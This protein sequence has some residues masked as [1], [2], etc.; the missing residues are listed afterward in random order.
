MMRITAKTIA[1]RRPITPTIPQ[2]RRQTMMKGKT[3]HDLRRLL[4][5]RISVLPDSEL[6]QKHAGCVPRKPLARSLKAKPLLAPD[7]TGIR[8]S[9]DQGQEVLLRAFETTDD[10]GLK[11]IVARQMARAHCRSAGGTLLLQILRKAEFPFVCGEA[12][13]ALDTLA[14]R[15]LGYEPEV[16]VDTNRAALDAIERW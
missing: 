1:V 8:C 4:F 12:S 15:Q 6:H 10:D 2:T 16:S 14:G 5:I 3:I 9:G 11:L 7:P 13:A